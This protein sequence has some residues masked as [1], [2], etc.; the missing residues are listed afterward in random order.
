[1]IMINATPDQLIALSGAQDEA[2]LAADRLIHSLKLSRTHRGPEKLEAEVDLRE[3]EY[4]YR[5]KNLFALQKTMQ[6]S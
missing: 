3:Q 4:E 5:C 2:L 6:V 1:M